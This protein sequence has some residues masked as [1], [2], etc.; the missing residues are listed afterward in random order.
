MAE[1]RHAEAAAALERAV[2]AHPHLVDGWE[3]LALAQRQLG[4]AGGRPAVFRRRHRALRRHARSWRCRWRSLPAAPRAP[5]RR[6]ALRARAAP[7][8]SRARCGSACSRGRRWWRSTAC[9]RRSRPPRPSCAAHPQDADVHYQ[10]GA[11][12]MARRDL[13]GAEAELRRALELAPDHTA[14]LSDLAVLLQAQGRAAEAEPLLAELV[15]LRPGDQRRRRQPGAPAPQARCELGRGLAAPRG[16]VGALAAAARPARCA[17]CRAAEIRLDPGRAGRAGLDRHP[18]L[19]SPA[20]LRLQ[21][22]RDPGDR[23]PAPRRDPVR[24]RL[25]PRAAH[26]AVA[27]LDAHRPAARRARRARQHRATSSTPA[28]CRTC[29]TLLKAPRLRDRRRGVELRAARRD[30]ARPRLR[31]LRGR[32][33]SSAAGRGLGRLQRAGQRDPGARAAPGCAAVAGRAVLPLPPPL[34]AAHAVH[35][36]GAVG[37]ALR[38]ALRRRDRRRRRAWSASWSPSSSGSGSTTARWSCSSPTTARAWAT[39]ARTSTAC[40]STARASRC[41]CS[42][43]LPDGPA[44][45]AATVARAGAARRRVHDHRVARS[46]SSPGAPAACSLAAAARAA[47]RRSGGSTPR[48]SIPRFHFGWSDLASLIDRRWHYIEGPAPELYD[49][50]AAPAERDDLRERERR[51]AA[52]LRA[53]L[54]GIERAVEPPAAEDEETRRQLAALGYLGSAA[55]APAGPL[56]DP[57]GQVH[58]L[59]DLKAAYAAFNARD[60]AAAAAA[61]RR[62]VAANPRALD[63]WEQLGISLQELGE[64]EPALAAFQEAM[65][66]TGGGIGP[67]LSTAGALLELKRYDEAEAHARLALEE[68]PAAAHAVLARAA[69]ERRDFARAEREARAGAR[70]GDRHPAGAARAAGRG[71]APR[72]TATTRRCACSRRRRASTRRAR[73]PIRSWCAAS[74]SCTAR[75]SPTAA[76]PPA[77]SAASAR[78]SAASPTTAAATPTSR[79]SWRSTGAAP[80]WARCCARWSRR[81]RWRRATPRRSRR[82]GCSRTSARRRRCCAT[83]APSSP[84]TGSSRSWSEGVIASRP[85]AARCV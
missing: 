42:L 64:P 78:R 84:P 43:K 18:A 19:R 29:P 13:A 8:S 77:P 15:R 6:P 53:A 25:H 70:G 47:G 76:T 56:P 17:R 7:R 36:A 55:A 37:R 48:P 9:R 82:C 30:R 85:K 31:L 51:A 67:A 28:R 50:A 34:R 35:A 61:F 38:R 58:V 24:A 45:A 22:R 62:V 26:P 10:V 46:G 12:R 44:A 74:S 23:R 71:A 60:Y 81:G 1:G 49:L 27:R 59:R 54:A 80:R 2:A 52:E 68:E 66:L 16:A 79:C 57:K 75:S 11:F 3:S 72:R 5:G 14:A 69:L 21:G 40:C 63:A 39:T 32:A 41:R 83:R 65:R 33:S 20:R 4:A 73:P